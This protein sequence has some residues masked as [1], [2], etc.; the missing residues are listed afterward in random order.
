MMKD[1]S[2]E[3]SLPS[4]VACKFRKAAERSMNNFGMSVILRKSLLS[5]FL[6]GHIIDIDSNMSWS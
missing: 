6:G 1:E 3:G 4:D 5:D 2:I